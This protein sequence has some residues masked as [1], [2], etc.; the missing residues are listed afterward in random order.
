D[1]VEPTEV[2]HRLA[3]R[4]RVGV[5]GLVRPAAEPDGGSPPVTGHLE[6][7]EARAGCD[8]LRLQE[9]QRLPHRR[10]HLAVVL[11]QVAPGVEGLTSVEAVLPPLQ[12]RRPR[13]ELA[14]PVRTPAVPVVA[15]AP[16]R[17]HGA[18]GAAARGAADLAEVVVL[19]AQ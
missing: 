14:D 19:L 8:P 10:D 18:R 17:P 11:L 15:T 6:L 16:L 13:E 2:G 12:L 5:A 3:E 9:R 7:T 4:Q 1:R